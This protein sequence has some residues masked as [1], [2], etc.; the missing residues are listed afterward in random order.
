MLSR[1]HKFIIMGNASGFH[2]KINGGASSRMEQIEQE[3]WSWKSRC[4]LTCQ[5][6]IKSKLNL[7]KCFE[8]NE[9]SLITFYS[10]FNCGSIYTINYEYI[11]YHGSQA[12]PY[13]FVTYIIIQQYT[14]YIRQPISYINTNS[15][16]YT[17]HGTWCQIRH[18]TTIPI[19]HCTPPDHATHIINVNGYEFMMHTSVDGHLPTKHGV[20]IM[21]STLLGMFSTRCWSVAEGF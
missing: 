1:W 3:T 20:V 5:T 11:I 7:T 21:S 18:R 4:L 9:K 2:L 15:S 14:V 13:R 8:K 12:P 10:L 19:S 16:L 6:F 17:R